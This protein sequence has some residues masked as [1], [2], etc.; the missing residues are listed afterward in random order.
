MRGIWLGWAALAAGQGT[1][2]AGP[3]VFD[4][5]EGYGRVAVSVEDVEG[6]SA[7]RYD[8]Y[9]EIGLTR[10]WTLTAKAERVQFPDAEDFNAEGYRATL[11]RALWSRE[12]VHVSVEGG[13]VYG[14]AIGG[15][16]GCDELGTE[17][18]LT[19]GASG[20]WSGA[21]WYTFA[22]IATRLHGEQ[23]WRDRVE[24]GAG[25][26]IARNVYFTN[27]IWLERGSEN[28]R[29]TKIETG[30]L[31]RMNKLD[32]SLAVREEL[33]GRFDETGVV[34]ALARRF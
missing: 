21:H 17:F 7:R 3:W 19:S 2:V 26:E 31:Y 14:A 22:D 18:R 20:R 16:R 33:S 9:S 28:A 15:V 12:T 5:G 13:A 1:A 24:I 10:S 8:V 29:S 34:V 6:L 30:V 11:R 23:C 4:S 25:R 32:F 27:Q